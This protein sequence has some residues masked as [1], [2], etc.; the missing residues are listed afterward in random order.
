MKKTLT[1]RQ[2]ED[3]KRLCK[4]R[5]NGRLLSPEGLRFICQANGFDATAIGK[6][7]LE[8]LSR[9]HPQKLERDTHMK[10]KRKC[11]RC[12]ANVTCD[13]DMHNEVLILERHYECSACGFIRHWG[14][15]AVMPDDSEYEQP[16]PCLEDKP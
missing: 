1:K 10:I 8:V 6:H 16:C 4:D 15:G 11:E 13:E 2:I 12:G 14:Y 9:I 5:A 3:Y 7:F